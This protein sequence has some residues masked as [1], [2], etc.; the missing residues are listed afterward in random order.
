MKDLAF[1]EYGPF[2]GGQVFFLE[3]QEMI[4]FL[5]FMASFFFAAGFVFF[6]LGV[7]ALAGW[8]L[9]GHL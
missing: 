8:F 5:N 4:K 3:I 6:I 1:S 7:I 2:G 9:K